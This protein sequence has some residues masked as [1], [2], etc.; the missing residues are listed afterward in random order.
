MNEIVTKAEEAL[1]KTKELEDLQSKVDALAST[2]LEV[3]KEKKKLDNEQRSKLAPLKF[4]IDQIRSQLGNDKSRLE[5]QE[6]MLKDGI[7]DVHE[8]AKLF[9]EEAYK[10]A[11]AA[12]AAGDMEKVKEATIRSHKYHLNAN[13]NVYFRT[14]E[15]YEIV[16]E[17][18]LP[19]EY[20]AVDPQKIQERLLILD[21]KETI[22]G[23]KRVKKLIVVVRE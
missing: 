6:H 11:E 12:R 21:E 4:E 22:P 7:R 2:L 14:Q 1:Q 3:W 13:N 16:D 23:V 18:L 8:Q 10:E 9:Q 15:T 5:I 19:R 17:A 20:L